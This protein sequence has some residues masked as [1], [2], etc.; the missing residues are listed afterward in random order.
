[1]KLWF[2]FSCNLLFLVVTNSV[3][4]LCRVGFV[5]P[6]RRHK[7]L[8]GGLQG[9]YEI[10]DQNFLSFPYSSFFLL[11]LFS[12]FSL[13]RS[14]DI[15]ADTRSKSALVLTGH[16]VGRTYHRPTSSHGCQALLS[17][18]EDANQNG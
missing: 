11:N 6:K 18:C 7:T 15:G 10:L 13:L 9:G 1:M 16:F 4:G 2:Y 8:G 17:I 3:R 12:V 14:G 5:F